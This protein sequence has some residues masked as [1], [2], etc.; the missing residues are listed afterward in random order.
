MIGLPSPCCRS[1]WTRSASARARALSNPAII[2]PMGPVAEPWQRLYFLPLPH[3]HRLLRPVFAIAEPR[4]PSILLPGKPAK[5]TANSRAEERVVR[6]ALRRK[7]DAAKCID[8]L[9]LAVMAE[10]QQVAAL[11]PE[12][13]DVA[14]GVGCLE[15]D[16]DIAAPVE[17][18]EAAIREIVDLLQEL[19]NEDVP[20]IKFRVEDQAAPVLA[21]DGSDIL[22][23]DRIHSAGDADIPVLQP[24]EPQGAQQAQ[25]F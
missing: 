25:Q 15:A 13:A 9:F 8:N 20:L 14:P 10:S 6:V 21:R 18:G 23:A 24:A 2:C 4:Y 19:G 3:G 17:Q 16:A 5:T 1:R 7:G 11:N 22:V 12:E